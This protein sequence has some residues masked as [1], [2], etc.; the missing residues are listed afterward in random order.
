MKTNLF[1]MDM[2]S[3]WSVNGVMRFIQELAEALAT[4]TEY[5]IIWVRFIHQLTEPAYKKW[6]SIGILSE[7]LRDLRCIHPG[8]MIRLILLKHSLYALL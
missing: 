5:R 2:A 4:N 8:L 3:A 6:I 1:L 7:E